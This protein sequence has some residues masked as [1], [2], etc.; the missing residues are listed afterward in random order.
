MAKRGSSFEK[1]EIHDDVVDKV[2]LSPADVE[3]P[4]DCEKTVAG[5]VPWSAWFIVV[6]ELCERFSYYGASLI[7]QTY[8]IGQLGLAKNDATALNRGFV[9]LA[10]FTTVIGAVL[11]DLKLGKFRTIL[12]FSCFYIVGLSMLS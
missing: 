5:R 11:A 3:L 7:F 4:P 12:L 1:L 2:S 6:T 8:M 9:F 10:Y